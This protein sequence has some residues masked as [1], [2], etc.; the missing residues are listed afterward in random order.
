M[1]HQL[2]FVMD[3]PNPYFILSTDKVI[4]VEDLHRP[5]RACVLLALCEVLHTEKIDGCWNATASMKPFNPLLFSNVKVSRTWHDTGEG[6]RTMRIDAPSTPRA[7]CAC[8]LWLQWEHALSVTFTIHKVDG[9][10]DDFGGLMRDIPKDFEALNFIYIPKSSDQY[11]LSATSSRYEDSDHW[12]GFCKL[13]RKAW[14]CGS[15]VTVVNAASLDGTEDAPAILG[16][17]APD[18]LDIDSTEDIL[19]WRVL[20]AITKDADVPPG[21]VCPVHFLTLEEYRAEVGQLEYAINTE[22]GFIPRSF[23]FF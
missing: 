14:E 6:L 5:Q 10:M 21:P 13:V 20:Q 2:S 8:Y 4:T 7:S 23:G 18:S 3:D 17:D 11:A 19:R 16:N 22:E 15:A 12:T 1:F 9:C